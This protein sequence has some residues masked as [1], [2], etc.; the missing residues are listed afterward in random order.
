MK[1][2]GETPRWQC[3]RR[4]HSASLQMGRSQQTVIKVYDIK[5]GKHVLS[6][7]NGHGKVVRC[8]LWSRLYAI[9]SSR[10]QRVVQFEVGIPRQG[11]RLENLGQAMYSSSP[12]P[13]MVPFVSGIHNLAT[14]SKTRCS[15]KTGY[16]QSL[17]S[18][19]VNS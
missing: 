13:L 3:H 8:V 16:L 5:S 1:I 10:R 6:P 15:M 7:I 14:R 19:L 12:S 2:G 4:T 18:L 17:F 9:S 11:D